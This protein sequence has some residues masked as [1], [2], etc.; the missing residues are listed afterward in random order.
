LVLDFI[1]QIPE[2]EEIGP[3]SIGYVVNVFVKLVVMG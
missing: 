1:E 3:A 2:V